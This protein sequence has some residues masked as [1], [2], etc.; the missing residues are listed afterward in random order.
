M[1][2]LY[3]EGMGNDTV[4]VDIEIDKNPSFPLRLMWVCGFS[5]R[6]IQRFF[7]KISAVNATAQMLKRKYSYEN[8]FACSICLLHV[9]E[10]VTYGVDFSRQ[11]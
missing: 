9:D 3:C 1:K 10:S 6:Y 5:W 11:L 7:Q 4:F 8:P 2:F